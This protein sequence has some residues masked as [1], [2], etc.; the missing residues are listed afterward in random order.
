MCGVPNR[1]A[2]AAPIDGAALVPSAGRASARIASR[3]TRSCSSSSVALTRG[4]AWNRVTKMSSCS[5][6]VSATSD[7]PWWWAKKARTIS[8]SPAPAGRRRIVCRLPRLVVDRF[9]EPESAVEPVARQSRQVRRRRR[10]IDEAGE[11]GGVRRHDQFV[12]ESALQSEAG[13]A[14]RLVLIV[15]GAIGEGVGRL[16]DAPRHPPLL[17]VLDLPAHAGAAALV[18]QRAGIRAQQQLRHQ[19]LEHRA[20]PRHQRGAAVDV[21]DQASEMEPVMLRHV[22]LGDGDETGEP[23]FRRQQVV[24]RAC[25]GGRGLLRPRADS[26]SRRCGAGDRRGSRTACS[27]RARRLA[28]PGARAPSS[29]AS[30]ARCPRPPRRSRQRRPRRRCRPTCSDDVRAAAN[31]AAACASSL[32]S[33]VE[34]RGIPAAERPASLGDDLAGQA[35]DVDDGVAIRIAAARSTTRRARGDRRC[36]SRLRAAASASAASRRASPG[37]ARARSAPRRGCRCRP[38]RRSEGGAAPASPCR[39]S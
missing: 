21:G 19:V 20:A 28:A 36:R 35:I 39:T 3:G 11:R 23:R 1:R 10:R 13:H 22:A 30:A 31:G 29:C 17:A 34:R 9:V 14:E 12:G 6:L 4:S 15:A 32:A 26:R 18:E 27:R 38:S 37:L 7:M 8:G 16:G 5:T 33:A 24:E 25:P 2:T